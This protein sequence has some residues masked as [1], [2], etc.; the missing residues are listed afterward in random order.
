MF[1]N[2][3][4]SF[5][6]VASV[7]VSSAASAAVVLTTSDVGYTGPELDLSAYENG[8]YNFTFGPEFLPNGMTFTANPGGGGNS[9]Q[10]SVIGQGPY[11]LLAN[12]SFGGNAVY[13]GVDSAT[14]YAELTFDSLISS[15]GGYWNYAPNAG[16]DPAT[17]SAYGDNGL[18]GTFDLTVMAPISTPGG[19]NEFRFRGIESDMTDIRTIR[20]GGDYILLAGTPDGTV[21]VP[22]VP[23]PASALLLLTG[24]AGAAR[25]ARRKS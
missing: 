10:G 6:I 19:F 11:G 13:I 4:Q 25:F 3:I 24:L 22:D 23:L 20:F 8:Q 12:G 15:F 16:G 9:G 5:A 14:G 1:I 17:I 2:K 7:L 18:L 21:P